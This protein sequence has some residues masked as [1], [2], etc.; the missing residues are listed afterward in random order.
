M[1]NPLATSLTPHAVATSRLTFP[2]STQTTLSATDKLRAQNEAIDKDK[3]E[4]AERVVGNGK[5]RARLDPVA[6]SSRSSSVAPP[7]L[8]QTAP[9]VPLKTRVVQLLALGPTEV[10]D[11]VRRVGGAEEDIMRVVQVVSN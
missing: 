1:L 4:R 8:P 2:L 10:S 9:V 7:I 3:K 11:I 5:P 6:A